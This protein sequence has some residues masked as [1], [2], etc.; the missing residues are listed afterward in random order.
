M[1]LLYIILLNYD[2]VPGEELLRDVEKSH[3]ILQSMEEASVA[4]RSAAL[5]LEVIEVA[6]T[7]LAQR[8]V[9]MQLSSMHSYPPQFGM[10]VNGESDGHGVDHSAMDQTTHWQ[11]T[12]FAEDFLGLRRVDML[13]TLID[14]NILGEFAAENTYSAQSDLFLNLGNH[15]QPGM[16]GSL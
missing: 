11:R 14:P 1:I 12:L 10:G 3:E 2:K 15:G 16:W 4:R 6:K 9:S 13:S 8:R 5:M 7:Y